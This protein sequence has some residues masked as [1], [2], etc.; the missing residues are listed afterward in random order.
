MRDKRKLP[1]NHTASKKSDYISGKRGK[2]MPFPMGRKPLIKIVMTQT[3]KRKQEE[4]SPQK[5][6]K[7]VKKRRET[8][9]VFKICEVSSLVF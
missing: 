7:I 3:K 2:P 5:K 4:E 6:K 8:K 9:N 1:R